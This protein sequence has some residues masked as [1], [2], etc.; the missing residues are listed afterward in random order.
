MPAPQ[1]IRKCLTINYFNISKRAKPLEFWSFILFNVS[2]LLLCAW[3]VVLTKFSSASITVFAIVA[4]FF[5]IP[6][7][8]VSMRRFNDLHLPKSDFIGLQ[9]GG[10]ILCGISILFFHR[11]ELAF[12]IPLGLL[13]LFLLA[14]LNLYFTKKSSH[15]KLPR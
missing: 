15:H 4:A 14:L 2:T 10:L 11:H 1:R 8:T 12:A 6:N 7:Q 5:F 3:I 13:G 9:Y